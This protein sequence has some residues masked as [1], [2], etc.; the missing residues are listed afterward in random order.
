[1]P[2]NG[3]PADPAMQKTRSSGNGLMRSLEIAARKAGVE[4]L[5][6][7]K[8]TSIYRRAPNAGPVLGIAADHKGTPLDIRAAKRLSLA[9]AARPAMSTSGACSIRV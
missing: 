1:M 2:H 6:Q 4:M 5:L 3:E 7:H 8:M 9:P